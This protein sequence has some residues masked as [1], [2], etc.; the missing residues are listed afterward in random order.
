MQRLTPFVAIAALTFLP[1]AIRAQEKYTVKLKEVGVGQTL[2]AESK[3]VTTSTTQTMGEKD[4]TPGKPSEEKSRRD[5]VFTETVL[6]RPVGQKMPTKIK[7]VYDKAT[8]T[9][10]GDAKPQSY[11]GKTVLIEKKQGG[12][13]F[14]LEGGEVFKDA[15]LDNEFNGGQQESHKRMFLPPQAVAVGDTWKVDTTPLLHG[16][17]KDEKV[18]VKRA[19][20]TGKL[21]KVYAKDGH[22]FGVIETTIA[23]EFMVDVKQVDPKTKGSLSATQKLTMKVTFDGCID[24]KLA[25]GRV[26]SSTDYVSTSLYRAADQ[27]A[28]T[29]ITTG[30]T[31]GEDSWKE[32]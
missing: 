25:Q 32:K 23:L 16:F 10:T 14:R 26:Q 20:G 27:P 12:Y 17:Q 4:K 7:R 29:I 22:Q 8:L 3:E 9:T 18:T 30:T 24:G 6:E 19:E 11:H 15:A 28:I 2:H 31:T 5:L 1:V 21:V 13:E